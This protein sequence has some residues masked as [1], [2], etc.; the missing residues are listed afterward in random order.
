M[1]VML[2]MHTYLHICHTTTHIHHGHP[3]TY[4]PH[5]STHTS[6]MHIHPHIYHAH[7]P[8]HPC[9]STYTSTYTSKD[10]SG[11]QKQGEVFNDPRIKWYEPQFSLLGSQYFTHVWGSSY[12]VSGR[13]AQ[14]L[15]SLPP[16]MLRFFNNEGGCFLW[17]WV[18]FCF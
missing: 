10:Y 4:S 15:A 18:C 11:C 8:T 7:P 12:V 1:D 5:T 6:T 2:L 17:G 13:A 3:P 9:T 14:A 16:G